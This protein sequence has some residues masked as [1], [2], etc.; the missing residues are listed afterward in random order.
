MSSLTIYT[1]QITILDYDINMIDGL[2]SLNDVH[3][4][5]GG[6]SKHQPSFFVRN[7]EVVDLTE[8]IKHSANLQSAQVLLKVNGGRKRGTYA[9]KELVYRYAMWISPKFALIVIR[10]FDALV[11]RTDAKQREALVTACDKLAIGNTLRSDVY[12]TVAQHFGYEKVTEIPVPLLPEA[13]AFVYEA[14]LARQKPVATMDDETIANNRMWKDIGF[15]K[16][17]QVCW[18]TSDL[19]NLLAQV[20]QKVND[21][22]RAHSTIF[23]SF[24]EQRWYGLTQEQIEQVK[25]NSRRFL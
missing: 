23:D 6:E 10:T 9:C 15:A 14:I 25:K 5:S 18:M 8:E 13:V 22:K 3:K 24:N 1:P 11:T 17:E 2:Y 16:T 7:Q 21:I 20:S 12:K 19:T 4:E